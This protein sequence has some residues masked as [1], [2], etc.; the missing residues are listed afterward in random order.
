MHHKFFF[1]FAA[2]YAG[3]CHAKVTAKDAASSLDTITENISDLEVLVDSISKKNAT[4]TTATQV[5][6]N[7]EALEIHHACQLTVVDQS[8]VDSY[9][10]IVIKQSGFGDAFVGEPAFTSSQQDPIC[11]SITKVRLTTLASGSGIAFSLVVF[12][13]SPSCKCGH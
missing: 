12:P 1:T 5:S 3:S 2:A 13:T 7:S 10:D 11:T 9:R 4:D 6:S 8:I